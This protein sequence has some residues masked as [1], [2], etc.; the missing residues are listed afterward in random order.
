M[1]DEILKV[2]FAALLKVADK[3]TKKTEAPRQPKGA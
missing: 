3:T 1:S 2:E